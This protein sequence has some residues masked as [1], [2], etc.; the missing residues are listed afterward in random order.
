MTGTVIRWI[1]VDLWGAIAAH[2]WWTALIVLGSLAVPFLLARLAD[3]APDVLATPAVA[4]AEV[5]SLDPEPALLTYRMEQ[6]KAMSP[7]GFEQTCA[8]LLARDRFLHA[9]RVGGSGDLGADVIATD[10]EGLTI[11]V[12]CRQV[13]QPVNSPAMQ[14]FNGTARPE[15]GADHAIVIGLN[16]FAQPRPAPGPRRRRRR[17]RRRPDS[18]TPPVPGR[19]PAVQR[20]YRGRS[21]PHRNLAGHP[22][23]HRYRQQTDPDSDTQARSAVQAHVPDPLTRRSAQCPAFRLGLASLAVVLRTR[24]LHLLG[25][26]LTKVEAA[27]TQTHAKQ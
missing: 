4:G 19:R 16:G 27:L 9:R 17:R 7:T 5:A 23:A 1:T 2:P 8:E 18:R 25:Q 20:R 22:A 21:P 11:V 14:Q 6:L 24:A 3:A 10:A 12:Q 15:H 13:S 26:M